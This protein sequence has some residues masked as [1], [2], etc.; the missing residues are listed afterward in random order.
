MTVLKIWNRSKKVRWN[1]ENVVLI[2]YFQKYPSVRSIVSFYGSTTFLVNIEKVSSIELTFKLILLDFNSLIDEIK[3][4]A[5]VIFFDKRFI[6]EKKLEILSSRRD[7]YLLCLNDE[8]CTPEVELF[9]RILNFSDCCS[10]D[11]ES[12]ASQ[13][14]EQSN[15]TSI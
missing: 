11:K 9:P 7:I 15:L 4:E 13:G 14:H 1:L 3:D 5:C 6:Q 8:S 12:K 10:T 2:P